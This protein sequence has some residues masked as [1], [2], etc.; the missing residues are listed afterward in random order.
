VGKAECV[1]EIRNAKFSS[2]NLK[3]R[4]QLGDLGIHERIILK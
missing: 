1:G 3:G 4:D 2:E